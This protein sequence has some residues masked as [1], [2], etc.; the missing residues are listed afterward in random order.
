MTVPKL[1]LCA[2]MVV[3]STRFPTKS[4]MV[5]LLYLNLVATSTS[6]TRT[7]STIKLLMLVLL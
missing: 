4:V 7:T 1:S 6:P 2:P 3:I 5:F